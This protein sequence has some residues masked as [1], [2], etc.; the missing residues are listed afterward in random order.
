MLACFRETI[1]YNA[2]FDEE[3]LTMNYFLLSN[4]SDGLLL[5][6]SP[7]VH[8]WKTRRSSSAIWRIPTVQ[9][10]VPWKRHREVGSLKA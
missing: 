10:G 5:W 7:A 2:I 1:L 8:V 6:Q 4:S 3:S 9:S